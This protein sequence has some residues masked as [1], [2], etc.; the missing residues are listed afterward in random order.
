MFAGERARERESTEGRVDV[1]EGVTISRTVTAHPVLSLSLFLSLS[2]THSH[3]H[4]LSHTQT[5]KHT[6][7]H[8]LSLSRSLL[9]KVELTSSRA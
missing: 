6:H 5:H 4:Y 1:V 2:L 9:P 3:K 7:T 8:S